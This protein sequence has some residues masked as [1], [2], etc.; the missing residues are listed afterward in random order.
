[1]M[2]G[3]WIDQLIVSESF[4]LL[5]PVLFIA[6]HI[7][8]PITF[9]PVLVICVTGGIV[10]GPFAGSLYSVIG[11]TIS[12][13]VFYLIIKRIPSVEKKL[14]KAGKALFGKHY[15]I[16]PAQVAILRLLPFIHFHLLSFFIY[17]NTENFSS[18][19]RSSMFS[20]IPATV[21]YTSLGKVLQTLSLLSAILLTLT[22]II[23][24][25]LFRKKQIHIKWD[26]FFSSQST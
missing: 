10:F 11:L 12:S 7:I 1:M 26:Q 23:T 16:S 14:C 24:A 13:I 17:E 9:M 6:I 15:T 20:V 3:E 22:I 5:A 2:H 18:Y 25:F 4:A 8:R 21:F 19:L